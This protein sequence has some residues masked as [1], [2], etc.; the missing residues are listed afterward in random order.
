MNLPVV[1]P[2]GNSPATVWGPQTLL[3]G[4]KNLLINDLVGGL[5]HFLFFPYVVGSSS[6]QLTFYIFQ[7]GW[8]HQPV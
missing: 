8:K 1:V 5:E 6:S 4:L 3:G 2:A 7:G